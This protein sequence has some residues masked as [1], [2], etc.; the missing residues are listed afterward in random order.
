MIYSDVFFQFLQ[1]VIRINC[2]STDFSPQKGVKVTF[3]ALTLLNQIS[4]I[5]NYEFVASIWLEIRQVLRLQNKGCQTHS[6]K[7]KTFKMI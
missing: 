7:C 3:F 4:V 6:E 2:L 5:R 1:V